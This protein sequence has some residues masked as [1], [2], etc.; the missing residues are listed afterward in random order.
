VKRQPLYKRPVNSLEAA[1]I[2]DNYNPA[3]Q[4]DPPVLVSAKYKVSSIV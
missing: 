3:P 2:A 4:P 1:E